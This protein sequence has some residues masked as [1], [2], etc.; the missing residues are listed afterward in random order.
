MA[1]EVS[2]QQEAR[3]LR[4]RI[5]EVQKLRL[6]ALSL[7]LKELRKHVIDRHLSGPT[8]P[9]SVRKQSGKLSRSIRL[10]KPSVSAGQAVATFTFTDPKAKVHIGKRGRKTRIKPVRSQFLAIP[11]RY[12]RRKSGE[13]FGGTSDPRWGSTYVFQNTIF[14]TKGRG[15]KTLPLFTLR[16]QVVVPQRVD[17]NIDIVKPG[18]LI[19]KRHIEA[20]L[21]KVF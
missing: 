17:I 10:S 7:T 1:S 11:T 13:P 20:G 18:E 16:E 15:R 2:P 21:K 6:S 4:R 19:Y 3:I 9:T 12:A 14:G 5:R 8:T